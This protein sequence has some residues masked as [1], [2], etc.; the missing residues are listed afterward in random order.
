V[1]YADYGVRVELDGRAAH[2]EEVRWRD[3]RRDN[4]A[5]QEGDA[6]LRFGFADVS[7]RPCDVASQVATILRRNGW[8]GEDRPC[9]H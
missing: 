2:P 1:R 4:L 3:L 8:P 6:V 9:G 7:E 5:I